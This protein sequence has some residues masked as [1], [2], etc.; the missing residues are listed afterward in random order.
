M[1]YAV[2]SPGSSLVNGGDLESLRPLLGH[3]SY[4]MVR[5][6]AELASEVV[7]EKAPKGSPG[8]HLERRLDMRFGEASR[9]RRIAPVTFPRG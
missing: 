5:C 9:S 8:D 2:H 4:A 6:H 7:A 1:T 3:F